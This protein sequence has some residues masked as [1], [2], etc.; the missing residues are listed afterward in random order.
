M[1]KTREN[2]SFWVYLRCEEFRVRF[3]FCAVSVYFSESFSS[4]KAVKNHLN[5]VLPCA[6][7]C[8]KHCAKLC[9]VEVAVVLRWRDL[10]PGW[11]LQE[12]FEAKFCLVY[13]FSLRLTV[14]IVFIFS[15]LGII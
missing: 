11:E 2:Q 3:S 6:P 10:T 15:F 5:H 4:Q 12:P 9:F 13:T 8:A 1:F 7:E 14:D